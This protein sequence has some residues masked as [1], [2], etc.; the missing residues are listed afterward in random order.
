M[1]RDPDQGKAQCVAAHKTDS[2]REYAHNT[3]GDCTH[4]SH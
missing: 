1:N 2:F 3:L 4:I